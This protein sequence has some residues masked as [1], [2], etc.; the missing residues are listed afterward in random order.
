MVYHNEDFAACMNDSCP[1]NLTCLRWQ[2]GTN[3]D[4]YQTYLDVSMC[5]GEF[6]V[7]DKDFK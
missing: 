4:P 3:K 7:D 5:E 1:K 2:L 6:Y